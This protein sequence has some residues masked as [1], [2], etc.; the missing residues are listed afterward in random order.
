MSAR[1]RSG[2]RSALS[3]SGTP[4][5]RAQSLDRGAITTAPGDGDVSWRLT[6]LA[7]SNLHFVAQQ[8]PDLPVPLREMRVRANGQEI[9][10]PREIDIDH[11]LDPSRLGSE[12]CDPVR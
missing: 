10:R 12:D 5:T 3:G 7:T 9:T 11:R 1:A 4:R 8:V 2:H 6:K